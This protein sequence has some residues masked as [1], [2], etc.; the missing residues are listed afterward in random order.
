VQQYTPWPEVV[1]QKPILGLE[2]GLVQAVVV[3]V[4]EDDT[5]QGHACTDKWR[6][7][8]SQQQG[9]VINAAQIMKVHIVTI[10][11]PRN[12][13]YLPHS[14]CFIHM[15]QGCLTVSKILYN[16]SLL[17]LQESDV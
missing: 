1:V 5:K 14:E 2:E 10:A 15:A 12:Q 6:S 7:T 13:C 11:G 3:S 17:Q 8:L 4:E 16:G 9:Q